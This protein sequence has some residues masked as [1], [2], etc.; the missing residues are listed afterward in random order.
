MLPMA[1]RASEIRSFAE[2]L[3]GRVPGVVLL[4]TEQALGCMDQ[5][6][7]TPGLEEVYL[8]LNDLHIALG[9]RFMF[10]PLASGIVDRVAQAAR[11]HGLRFGFG[12]IARLD[13]GMLPGRD[14]LAEHLRV[15]S[16][17]VILSRTFHRQGG[18]ASLEDEVRALRQAEAALARRTPQQVDADHRRIAERIERIA[19]P[20]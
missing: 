12:G 15:G 14:V 20:A 3:R 16:Q 10:E 11:R 9:L 18:E 13:E 1:A 8:G 4:E 7:G 2:A 6:I 17:A 19:A 5:W